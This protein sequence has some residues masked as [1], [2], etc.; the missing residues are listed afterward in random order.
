MET[1]GVLRAPVD[2][3]LRYRILPIEPRKVTH[4]PL[5]I[6]N[7]KYN[8]PILQP[9]EGRKSTFPDGR[10]PIHWDANDRTTVWLEDDEHRF[11]PIPWT[12]KTKTAIPMTDEVVKVVD[13]LRRDSDHRADLQAAARANL[14]QHNRYLEKHAPTPTTPSKP[15]EQDVVAAAE[16]FLQTTARDAVA[17]A[18][19]VVERGAARPLPAGLGYG[20]GFRTRGADDKR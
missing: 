17:A 3:D 15:Q 2:V 16:E 11:H 9:F 8:S 10:W 12:E 19:Q 4:G 5:R 20:L 14:S 7:R 1:Q 6:R 18:Q 13:L